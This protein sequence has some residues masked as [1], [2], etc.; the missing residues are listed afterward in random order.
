[1]V[2]VRKKNIDLL[3][4]FSEYLLYFLLFPPFQIIEYFLY[5]FQILANKTFMLLD[6]KIKCWY[7]VICAG[8]P[9]IIFFIW[10]DKEWPSK[11]P[12]SHRGA[13]VGMRNNQGLPCAWQRWIPGAVPSASR[14]RVSRQL[15]PGAWASVQLRHFLGSMGDFTTKSNTCKDSLLLLNI[16]VFPTLFKSDLDVFSTMTDTLWI[17]AG[18]SN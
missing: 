17:T 3:F 6:S 13:K 16:M 4:I 1:M 14:S 10:R 15:P 9:I 8:F 11:F 5:Y 18:S 2:N 7:M 12:N